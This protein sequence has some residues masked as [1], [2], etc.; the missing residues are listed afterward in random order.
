MSI[1][2][3]LADSVPRGHRGDISLFGGFAPWPQAMLLL[4]LLLL[5]QEVE[6]PRAN[7]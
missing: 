1:K 2:E 4:L 6:K 5:L 7:V 3:V